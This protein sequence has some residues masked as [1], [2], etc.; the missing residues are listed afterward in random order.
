VF[1]DESEVI[2]MTVIGNGL[3]H[4]EISYH[5]N[6]IVIYNDSD[7]TGKKMYS[8][9]YKGVSISLYELPSTKE[10]IM[11]AYGVDASIGMLHPNISGPEFE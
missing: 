5:G 4:I 9:K 7:C 1:I 8:V 3:D 2:F 11:F 6:S 10:V